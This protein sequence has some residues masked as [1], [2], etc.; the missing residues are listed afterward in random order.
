MWTYQEPGKQLMTTN[1]VHQVDYCLLHTEMSVRN[2]SWGVKEPVRRAD[3]LAT[4]MYRL[5]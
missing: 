5:S 3:K 2:I 1:F 4:F